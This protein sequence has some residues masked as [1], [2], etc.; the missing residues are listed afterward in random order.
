MGVEVPEE[1]QSDASP[2]RLPL[3]IGLIGVGLM[4]ALFAFGVGRLTAPSSEV[5]TATGPTS[6]T[7]TL[8][9]AVGEPLTWEQAGDLGEVWPIALLEHD[10]TLYLF[11]SSQIPF[12]SQSDEPTDLE[13]WAST[14]GTSWE[15]LGSVIPAPASV[16][17]VVS[18][19][20]GLMALGESGPDGP[21]SVWMSTDGTSW[22]AS[23]LPTTEPAQ[24]G[25]MTYMQAAGANDEAFVVFG[26]TFV[27]ADQVIF[28]ALPEQFKTDQGDPYG[29]GFGGPPF[30][31]TI[32][33]PLGLA[34][35]TATAEDLGFTEEQVELL[36]QG[37]PFEEEGTTLWRSSDGQSWETSL[38]EGGQ[39]EQV[40]TGSDGV[41]LASG[42]GFAG[43]ETWTSVDGIEW[44]RQPATDEVNIRGP[45]NDGL[46]GSRYFGPGEELV[47]SPDGEEWS[48]MGAEA[49]LPEELS[50]NYHPVTAGDA[51]IAAVANGYDEFMDMGMEF[52]E[53]EPIVLEKD[54][55]TLTADQMRGRLVLTSGDDEV[56]SLFMH[57]E[58]VHDEVVADFPAKTLTFL[59]PDTLEP[60]V[61]FT[62]QEIEEAEEAAFGA[63]GEMQEV[64]GE[65]QVFMF[66]ADGA[67]WTA[68]DLGSV[69]GEDQ[70]V[71]ELLVARDRVVAVVAQY[72]QNFSGPPVPPRVQLWT[73]LV[74]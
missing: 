57:S 24:P 71:S 35:F 64:G 55:Y 58:R 29:M 43:M 25:S 72:E 38:I 34:V 47:Y 61:T 63:F 56:L 65:Q 36:M 11:G 22:S 7:T 46:I 33:G 19:P 12:E 49:A 74:P 62:F 32:Y 6:T 18:T 28:D 39:I 70:D 59:D 31:A 68:H 73:A 17:S 50:W 23:E 3:L 60:L 15:S 4:I 42:Y 13:A 10:G 44:D 20:R 54:G 48:A 37:G 5:G 14:D 1:S 26:S 21:P 40:W 9:I 27:N 67:H 30:T 41:L 52:E 51:G 16:Q 66:S 8:E 69:F 2:S 53:P 45:W